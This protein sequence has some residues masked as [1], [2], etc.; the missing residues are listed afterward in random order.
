MD[1]LGTILTVALAILALAT[2]AG[3]G[4]QRGRIANLQG[5]LEDSDKELERQDRRREAAE[6]ELEAYKVTSGAKVTQLETDL[7]A[8]ARVVTG[9]AH[10]IAIG[11]KMDDHHNGAVDHWKDERSLLEEIRDRLPEKSAG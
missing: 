4:L 11:E 1:N 5:R 6:G 7:A 10:W 2:A 9:E 3:F 8:L